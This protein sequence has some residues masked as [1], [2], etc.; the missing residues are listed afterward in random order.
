M[1]DDGSILVTGAAGQL[2]SVGRTVTGCSLSCENR[3]RHG[4]AREVSP[5]DPRRRQPMNST[6]GE[7]ARSTKIAS[8]VYCRTSGEY[9]LRDG[10]A[11]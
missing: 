3:K 4:R 11:P 6:G 10:R 1:V 2:G 9:S 8:L 7:R 5:R